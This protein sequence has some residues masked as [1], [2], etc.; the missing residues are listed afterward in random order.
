LNNVGKLPV[1]LPAGQI[2]GVYYYSQVDLVFRRAGRK[3]PNPKSSWSDICSD[4][5]DIWVKE[6]TKFEIWYF[7]SAG[8]K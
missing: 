7:R 4:L 5:G 1:A 6:T 2:P 8:K 3:K